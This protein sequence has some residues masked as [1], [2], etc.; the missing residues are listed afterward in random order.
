MKYRSKYTQNYFQQFRTTPLKL[1]PFNPKTKKIGKDIANK[2]RK[3]INNEKVNV[4]HRGSTAFGILGKGDVD[5]G[6][7]A[8][9]DTYSETKLILVEMFG[10]PR[11]QGRTFAAFY[12]TIDGQEVEVSLMRGREAEVDQKLTIYL[13]GQ[14]ELL[15]E[16][17]QIKRKYSYSKREY[18][19]QRN[20]FLIKTI[21]AIP[22]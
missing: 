12:T 5:I 8:D 2:L 22:D 7:Y 9:G 6:V 14:H 1:K 10:K 17:E 20:K 15:E 16:Y 3:R 21:G 11:A 4:L 13:M 18:L 19:I